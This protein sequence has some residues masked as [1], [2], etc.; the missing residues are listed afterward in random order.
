MH[1]WKKQGSYPLSEEQEIPKIEIEPIEFGFDEKGYL[2]I[3]IHLSVGM[4]NMLGCLAEA[5]TRVMA[6]FG[7][8]G[9]MGEEQKRKA[10]IRP[11]NVLDGFRKRWQ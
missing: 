2:K 4:W 9:R 7:A 5:Q 3:K 6:Q 8:M 11:K 1:K 10:L